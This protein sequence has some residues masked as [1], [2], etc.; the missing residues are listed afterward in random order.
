MN[1]N[2]IT[3]ITD[4]SG[5]PIKDEHGRTLLHNIHSEFYHIYFLY[6]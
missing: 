4:E 5:T 6:S 3:V 2:V 1:G